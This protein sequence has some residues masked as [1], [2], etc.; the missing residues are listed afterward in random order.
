MSNINDNV[1]FKKSKKMVNFCIIKLIRCN[2]NRKDRRD[3]K[4]GP[5]K[6]GLTVNC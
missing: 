4:E 1:D 2:I 5:L 6:M 3:D